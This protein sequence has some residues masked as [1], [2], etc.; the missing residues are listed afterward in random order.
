MRRGAATTA[1]SLSGGNQQKVIVAREISLSP[2]VL[3]VAQPTR[4][5]D[6][7]AISIFDAVFW[8]NGTKDG[9]SFWFLSNWMRL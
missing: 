2:K 5:L 3:L 8:T 7:G 4:G 1:G 6:V 9:P